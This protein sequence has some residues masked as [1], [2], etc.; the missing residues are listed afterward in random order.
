[1]FHC[2]L[3]TPNVKFCNFLYLQ[4]EKIAPAWRSWSD[5]GTEILPHAI[6]T[7]WLLGTDRILG[8][9][10]AL[11]VLGECHDAI[12]QTNHGCFK[13]G[14]KMDQIPLLGLYPSLYTTNWGSFAIGFITLVT[15]IDHTTWFTRIH[16]VHQVCWLGP[17]TDGQAC[18]KMI[19]IHQP[20]IKPFGVIYWSHGPFSSMI[21]DDLPFKNGDFPVLPLK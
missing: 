3:G 2:H 1:M 15:S 9:Q 14:K 19:V 6:M 13:M 12:N 8:R 11:R 17:W 21:Y 18:A 10:S 16:L 20:K 5:L 7:R 4:P